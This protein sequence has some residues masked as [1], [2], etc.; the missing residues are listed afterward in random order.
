MDCNN[1]DCLWSTFGTCC[2]EDQM[3]A[4]KIATPN[5]LDCPASLRRDFQIQLYKLRNECEALLDK[6]NMKELIAIKKF[7]LSQREDK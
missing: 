4:A 7:I 6:R 2:H 5:Q 3:K 1:T